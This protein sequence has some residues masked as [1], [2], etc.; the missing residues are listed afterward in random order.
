MAVKEWDAT[1]L[2]E[3]FRYAAKDHANYL[4]QVG[5]KMRGQPTYKAVYDMHLAEQMVYEGLYGKNCLESPERLVAQLRT[6]R[7]HPPAE[8]KPNDP[9]Q[10]R[11]TYVRIVDALIAE[12]TGTS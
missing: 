1:S 9:A 7:D 8:A 11:A 10:F 12:F 3:R 5:P 4:R 2:D 6:M